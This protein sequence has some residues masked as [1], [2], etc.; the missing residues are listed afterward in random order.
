MTKIWGSWGRKR[1][2]DLEVL[3]YIFDYMR[4][5]FEISYFY[6]REIFKIGREI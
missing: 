5:K 6:L 1:G 3:F 2:N 4:E